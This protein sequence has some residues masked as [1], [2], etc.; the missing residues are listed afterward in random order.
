MSRAVLLA[1]GLACVIA[2]PARAEDD[3]K[4]AE[5]E[6]K[7]GFKALDAGDAAEALVHYQRS[8]ELMARPRTLFNIA[9]CQEQ[10]GQ[11]L[12]AWRN[13]HV[14]L[15]L[16]EARDVTI[17]DRARASIEALRA[18][19]RGRVV[20]DST[21]PGAEVRIDG[22]RDARGLTPLTLSLAPGAHVVRISMPEVAAVERTVEIS[23]D[24]TTSLTVALT[25]PS[26]IT[27]HVE[28][29][30]AVIEPEDGGAS[31][32]GTF[33]AAAS[34]GRHTFTIR[35]KGY[36]TEQVVVDAVAGRTYERRVTLQPDPSAATLVVE[37]MRGPG[38]TVTIALD[39]A[40]RRSRTRTALA[41]GS[42]ALGVAS[43]AGGSVLGVLALRGVTSDAPGDH[44]RGKSDALLADGLFVVGTA[45]IV[46]AWRLFRTSRST[47]TIRR[48]H[49]DR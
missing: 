47:A 27:I 7:L 30:D 1:L 29:D 21:P 24:A 31:V 19:L 41:W 25:L 6:Y 26:A 15:D 37:G 12:E 44:D 4:D 14:F 43:L 35:R 34:P 5:R 3:T 40:P 28:P 10:L 23:P 39:P 38:E 18:R 2:S 8:Y 11:D 20:V 42:A 22:A 45:A 9:T 16:A 49:G 32:E 48:V 36:Q 46:A 13:Y 17:A 33:E